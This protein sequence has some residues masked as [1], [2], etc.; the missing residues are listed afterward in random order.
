MFGMKKKMKCHLWVAIAVLIVS[1]AGN[2]Q[3]QQTDKDKA[4]EVAESFMAL[5]NAGRYAEG[6]E[7]ISAQFK[8]IEDKPNFIK[9]YRSAHKSYGKAVSRKLVKVEFVDSSSPVAPILKGI[10]FTYKSVFQRHKSMDETIGVF[11]EQ[12]GKWHVGAY[13]IEP[14][15]DGA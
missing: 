1:G 6:W 5:I 4:R 8:P 11:L 10:I 2:Y 12:D 9:F 3:A 14:W 7:Q 13:F 15:L